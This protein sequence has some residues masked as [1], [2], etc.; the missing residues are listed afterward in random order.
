MISAAPH[1]LWAQTPEK[2]APAEQST[3]ENTSDTAKE[4]TETVT[5]E[6]KPPARLSSKLPRSTLALDQTR[7]MQI[8]AASLPSGTPYW[9]NDGKEDFL[10]VWQEDKTGD[11]QGAVLII[12]AEGEHPSW[13]RTT[14][15][16]HDSLPNYG[17]ATMSI[18]LPDPVHIPLPARTLDAKVIPPPVSR[19]I[20]NDE[21]VTENDDSKIEST[22]T[23]P[24][25][26]ATTSIEKIPVDIPAT[27]QKNSPSSEEIEII[28]EERL[29][30]ALKFLHDK[31]Q[32]NIV[33]MGTGTGAIRS[34][35]LM[36]NIV[37]IID[38]ARLKKKIE[39]PIRGSIIFN[40]RN[41]M[42]S[43][44][45]T[46]TDWFFDPEMP[47]LDI[48]TTDDLRNISDAKARK[49]L[50]RKNNIPTHKQIK[51]TTLSYER[52]W[53]E[54][55]LSRRVRSFLDAYVQGIEVGNKKLKQPIQ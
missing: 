34:H 7:K 2:T 22:A 17:W 11:A 20:I 24:D 23:P 44:E 35:K 53:Q 21:A 36:K 32:F 47:V 38:D 13:P 26:T 10:A 30:A 54:N 12:H 45:E 3:A 51:L 29:T 46:Y 8:L 33:L 15:P 41:T 6:K 27:A 49:A 52:S 39:K 40:A 25:T 19:D 42:P 18:S 16:L 9:L 1:Q 4:E 48:Y 50:S 14:Q 43:G 28:A 55:Q 5:E 31:G 37:P